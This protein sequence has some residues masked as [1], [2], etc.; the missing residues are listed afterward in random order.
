MAAPAQADAKIPQGPVF[1]DE[2]RH[3]DRIRLRSVNAAT[4]RMFPTTLIGGVG[5]IAACDGMPTERPETLGNLH[6]AP[7]Q[8]IDVVF[9][10]TGTVEIARE[11]REGPHQLGFLPAHGTSPA[12]A[13]EPARPLPPARVPAPKRTSATPAPL[14]MQ[15]GAMGGAHRGDDIRAFNGRSGLPEIP[16]RRFARG[17]TARIMLRNA[18]VRPNGIHLHDRHFHELD[19]GDGLG[20]HRDRTLVAA[21]EGRDLLCVFG[22]SGKWLLHCHARG[23]QASGLETWVELA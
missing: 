10:V 11:T 21:D 22:T 16:L 5:R 12:P 14:A 4:A 9:D 19:A 15:G 20:R 13:T 17:E 6:L 8:R 7:G 3:G 1:A 23:H 18:T 2:L